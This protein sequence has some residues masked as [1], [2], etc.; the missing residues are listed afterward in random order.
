MS[1]YL[2]FANERR[3]GV[4]EA[5]RDCSNGEISKILSGMWKETS[6]SVKKAYKDEEQSKWN[7]YKLG[8]KEWRK[9]NDGRKKANIHKRPY[10]REIDEEEPRYNRRLGKGRDPKHPEVPFDHETGFDVHLGLHGMDP[11][12][13]PNPEEMM[14][15]SAL[16]GVRSGP[17]LM[18]GH[19]GDPGPFSHHPH[20]SS[21]GAWFNNVTGMNRSMSGMH[22]V[23]G[24][25]IGAGA[26]G[27]LDVS[28]F[29]Y[30]QHY[31]NSIG[32]G[33]QPA[34]LMAQIRGTQKN[35]Y[36]N[37][38]CKFKFSWKEDPMLSIWEC[39]GLISHFPLNCFLLAITATTDHQPNLSQLASL[40]GSHQHNPQALLASNHNPMGISLNN[41]ET[42]DGSMLH[43]N[44]VGNSLTGG[45][46]PFEHDHEHEEEESDEE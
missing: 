26:P 33:N 15:A 18:N 1:A 39:V 2:S 46:A 3:K 27:H 12:G 21:Y 32:A 19:V 31:G 23:M 20:H 38:F 16:R 42:G 30:S 14:A 45:M 41:G 25:H 37:L 28:N 22:G 34:I 11:S 6:S 29:P 17:Q 10:N 8:M 36:S 35:P 24:H 40:A 4:K 5:N 44:S 7:A 43:D 13:N 9:K